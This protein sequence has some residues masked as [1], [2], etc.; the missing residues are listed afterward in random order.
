[1]PLKLLTYFLLTVC[2]NATVLA[3]QKPILNGQSHP[4]NPGTAKWHK[5][6]MQ[7]EETQSEPVGSPLWHKLVFRELVINDSFP[8]KGLLQ[9]RDSLGWVSSLSKV[10]Y[11]AVKNRTVKAYTTLQVDS[12]LRYAAGDTLN[13]EALNK[14]IPDSALASITTFCLIED[15]HFEPPKMVVDILW[16]GAIDTKGIFPI[17]KVIQKNAHSYCLDDPHKTAFWIEFSSL[18]KELAN[19]VISIGQPPLSSKNQDYCA[20]RKSNFLTLAELNRQP[21]NCADFFDERMFTSLI[22]CLGRQ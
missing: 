16:I 11:T 7:K 10:L 15:W 18:K 8:N 22:Y 14:N 3:Q 12:P 19:Y 5:E 6:R 20:L 2:I 4:R 21:I 13:V 1:M 9:M 17:G